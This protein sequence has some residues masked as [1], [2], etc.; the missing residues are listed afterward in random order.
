ML[1]PHRDSE[2]REPQHQ[3]LGKGEGPECD[4]QGIWHDDRAREEVTSELGLVK[5]SRKR[6]EGGKTGR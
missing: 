3:R 1:R 6:G 5:N 4:S 2:Q